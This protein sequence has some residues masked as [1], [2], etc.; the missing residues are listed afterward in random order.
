MEDFFMR[1]LK[2][3]LFLA[4]MLT[5]TIG[6]VMATGAGEGGGEMIMASMATDV[7]GLGDGSFNDGSYAG[8]QM[9]EEKGIAAIS[10]I[11]S[12]QQTDY[13][14]NLSGL[15]EDGND[16]VFAVGF[17]M[18]DAMVEAA[19]YNPDTSF[20]GVDIFVDP[21]TAPDNAVGILFKEHEAGYLAG[22]VAGYMTLEYADRSDRLNDQNVVGLV[23]GMDIPPCER[24]EVGFIAGVHSVNPD[25]EVLTANA[26]SFTDQ[27]KG[28]ELTL[29]MVDQGADIVF[30]IAGLTGLGVISGAQEA[31]ICAIG[32]DVD[33][34]H[35]APDT[36]ITSAMKGLTEATFQVI[37]M[38]S[39]GTFEGGQNYVLGIAENGVG[40]A[41]YHDFEDVVPNS[42]QRAV[43]QAA[44]DI[45]AGRIVVPA[46][47][48]EL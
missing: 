13:I 45:A 8:L 16:V 7:G 28:K 37:Q 20:A 40:I 23:L 32:V 46:T 41:P 48:A 17:M 44:K 12:K 5:V 29:A 36:V 47:R 31:G 39:N 38:V 3:V 24:Y 27:A 43:E 33:Q 14:P 22:I 21:S 11:E 4:L 10:V 15:A 25:C 6:M 1:G 34:A 35:Y 2:T 30:Q 26:G 18:S 19:E 9:A 42:V